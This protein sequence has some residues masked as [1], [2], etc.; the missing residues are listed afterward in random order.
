MQVDEPIKLYNEP[1]NMFVASFI[2]SP[3]MNFL[4]GSVVADS[5]QLYFAEDGGPTPARIK[6]SSTLERI[7]RPY[8]GKSI[9]FG[10]RPEDVHDLLTVSEYDADQTLDVTVDVAEPMGNETFLYLSTGQ[11]TF[12]GRVR[13]D[14]RFAANQAIKVWLDLAKVQ[15]FDPVTENALR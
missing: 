1:R 3:P 4:R 15:L 12:T 2:G 13:S 9:V 6:L 14:A 5:A 11:Q 8:L 10:I 7:A